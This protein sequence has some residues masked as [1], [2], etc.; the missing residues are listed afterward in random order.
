SCTGVGEDIVSAA[1]AAKIVT[2]VTDGMTLKNAFQKSFNELAE[3]DGFAGAIGID[4][5]GNMFW[6]ESHPKIV[7]AAYDGTN[8][9][10]FE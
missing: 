7:F 3:F 4:K 10:I 5:S 1:V 2:R 6:Q 9:T 8:L